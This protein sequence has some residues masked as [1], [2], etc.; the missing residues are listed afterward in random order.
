VLSRELELRMADRDG[1]LVSGS[2]NVAFKRV[3]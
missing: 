2:F 1:R 3:R